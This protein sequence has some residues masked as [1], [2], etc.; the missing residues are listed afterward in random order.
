MELSVCCLEVTGFNFFPDSEL[1][2]VFRCVCIW[3]VKESDDRRLLSTMG[4]EIVLLSS[5]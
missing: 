4:G 5:L 2:L 1:S 3:R